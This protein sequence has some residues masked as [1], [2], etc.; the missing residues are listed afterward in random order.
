MMRKLGSLMA[1]LFFFTG[2]A[3]VV[4]QALDIGGIELKLGQS[5][6]SALAALGVA[7]DVRY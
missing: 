6:S 3:P 2:P 7:Y 4:A 1:L 5:A